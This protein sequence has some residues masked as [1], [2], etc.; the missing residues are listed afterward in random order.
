M[1]DPREIAELSGLE[2][3]G[4]GSRDWRV[5]LDCGAVPRTLAAASITVHGDEDP[6][7]I[8]ALANEILAL[9][10]RPLIAQTVIEGDL[11][12]GFQDAG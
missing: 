2:F 5:L 4:L 9:W 11:G 3:L 1:A 10:G 8:V 6:R 7:A 12:A